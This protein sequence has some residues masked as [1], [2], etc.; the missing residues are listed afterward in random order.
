MVTT[1]EKFDERKKASIRSIEDIEIE[2]RIWKMQEK[3]ISANI[4]AEQKKLERTKK[5]IK[6]LLA[7]L[8][9]KEVE[10]FEE[11]GIKMSG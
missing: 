8:N 7:K 11:K 9:T 10:V 3:E 2:L 4:E 6:E 1:P 5:R